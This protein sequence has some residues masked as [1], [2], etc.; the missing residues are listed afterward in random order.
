MSYQTIPEHQLKKP[1]PRN[2]WRLPIAGILCLCT[3]TLTIYGYK[4]TQASS[5]APNT[6]ELKEAK[7]EQDIIEQATAKTIEPPKIDFE[8]LASDAPLPSAPTLN[9]DI[10]EEMEAPELLIGSDHYVEDFLRSLKVSAQ[11]S[12]R[13]VINSQVFLIGDY[14]DPAQSIKLH[15]LRQGVL[16]FEADGQLYPYQSLQ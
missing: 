3:L 9:S 15:G 14:V 16:Y 11:S 2:R 12:T 13:A 10:K 7:V 6:T 1:T 4:R 8:A 5:P